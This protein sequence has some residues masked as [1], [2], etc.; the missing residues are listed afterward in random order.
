MG[1]LIVEF[2]EIMSAKFTGNQRVEFRRFR[3]VEFK[4][5][6]GHAVSGVGR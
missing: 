2:R 3:V 4:E 6:V 5:I 1:K